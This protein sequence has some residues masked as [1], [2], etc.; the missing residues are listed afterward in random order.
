MVDNMS[1]EQHRVIGNKVNISY[2]SVK[3]FFDERGS[4]EKKHLYNYV[5]YLDDKPEVAIERD[6]QEKKWL[7]GILDINSSTRIIDVGCG[8]GRWGE[9]FLSKGAFYLGVDG[10][11]KMIERASENL[12]DY[13]NKKLLLCNLQDIKSVFEDKKDELSNFDI[14]F[15]SGVFMYLNDDDC[16]NLMETMAQVC[17]KNAKICIIESM[18]NDERLT[19]NNFYSSDL[20]Q[21]YS[22]IYRTISEYKELMNRAFSKDF[23][24]DLEQLLDFEDGL[25]KKR[26]HVTMEHCFIWEKV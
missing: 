19:L 12:K 26:E 4:Q 22:A 15:V 18:S 25:Q 3:D 23:K 8:V 21:D 6:K 20:K 9:F 7:D 14:V 24:L 17:S 13:D 2:G 5:M 1:D 16:F 10:N 11:E